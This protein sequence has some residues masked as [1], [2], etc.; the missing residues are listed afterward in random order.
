VFAGERF[1]EGLV[2]VT[3]LAAKTVVDVEGGDGI[4]DEISVFPGGTGEPE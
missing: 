3:V 4:R 2:I 1:G